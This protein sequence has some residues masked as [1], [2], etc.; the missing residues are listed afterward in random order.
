MIFLK[1]KYKILPSHSVIENDEYFYRHP[2][3][4][5]P[6]IE[7]DVFNMNDVVMVKYKKNI[8]KTKNIEN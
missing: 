8:T 2:E 5:R 6:N 7:D 1:H 4:Y 3:M